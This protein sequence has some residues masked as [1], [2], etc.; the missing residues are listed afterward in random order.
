MAI[1]NGISVN[2]RNMRGRIHANNDVLNGVGGNEQLAN[3]LRQKGPSMAVG[4]SLSAQPAS[5][6]DAIGSK[7]RNNGG[8]LKSTYSRQNIPIADDVTY[9]P[10]MV[11]EQ[12][13]REQ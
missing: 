10:W 12:R 8:T 3:A 1:N 6:L 7:P 5:L 11:N 4:A 13:Y 2:N 9:D